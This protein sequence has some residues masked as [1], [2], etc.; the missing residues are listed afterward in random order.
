VERE[1][2]AFGGP[3]VDAAGDW[4]P[5]AR[6]GLAVVATGIAFA[7]KAGFPGWFGPPYILFYP[8]VMLS[9]LLGGLWSGLLATGLSAFIVLGWVLPAALEG[10]PLG[11]REMVSFAAFTSMGV[12]MSVVAALQR[13]DRIQVALYRRLRQSASAA[14]ELLRASEERLRLFVEH[15]PAAIAMLDREMRYLA[16]SHRYLVDYRLADQPLV[17]RSHYELFPDIPERWKEIHRRCLA[18]AVESCEED[19]FP[20]ADGTLDWVRWEIRPWRDAAGRIGGI[21]L[22][23]EL[24]TARKQAEDRLAAEHERLAVTLQSIGDAVIATDREA[25]VT[26]FNEVAAT[27]TGWPAAEALGRPL[28]EVFRIVAEDTR[29]PMPTPVERVLREGATVGLADHATLVARDGRERPIADSGAPIRDAGGRVCGVVLVFRDQTEERRAREALRRSEERFRALIERSTDLILLLDAGG[30]I[31]FFS[32][33]AV[34]ALGWPT[35]ET[36][37][38]PVADL[39]HPEDHE[40]LAEA[41][42]RLGALPG[43][44]GSALL[45][46]RHRDGSWRLVQ[47]TVRNL[48]DDP[49]VGGLVVNGRDVTEQRQL[50]D[51][52][53]QSQKLETVGRLAGGVAHDFNNLL[54]VILSYAASLEEA[55]SRGARADVEEVRQIREAGRRASDLTRRLLAFAR[56]QPVAPAPLDLGEVVRESEKMLRRLMGEEVDLRVDLQPD[57]WIMLADRGQVEQVVLNLAVNARDAMPRGGSLVIETR[58]VANDEP[59]RVDGERMPGDWVR[60]VFRDSGTGMTAEV[61][62]H[63]FEPFFTTKEQGK[64]TGLGLATVYGIVQ[65]A[66]GHLHVQSERGRGTTFEVCFPRARVDPA[67]RPQ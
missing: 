59:R 39:V 12:C 47:A 27:L 63:L 7:L 60:L 30:G 10:R 4:S 15:A 54:T 13:R 34:E 38:R 35:G 6:I 36:L 37:G 3:S 42:G 20:R 5:G 46:W 62:A 17:G 44:V 33:G 45:R 50:E 8:A 2:L 55:L 11:L 52:L 28:A 22:L 19:P 57:L 40:H 14:E 66:G 1:N 58:N 26:V 24:V 23:T 41:L 43:E 65:K 64:G 61:R 32:Q 16:A 56:K 18:G 51:E 21:M 31:R 9:A 67:P 49:V 25:V 48:L 53:R 29:Q